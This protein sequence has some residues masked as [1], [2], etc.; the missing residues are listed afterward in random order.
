MKLPKLTDLATLKSTMKQLLDVKKNIIFDLENIQKKVSSL[1]KELE[2]LY[3]KPLSRAEALKKDLL[4]LEHLH[5][6]MKNTFK[7]SLLAKIERVVSSSDS[8]FTTG[9]YLNLLR[10]PHST[11]D[12][13]ELNHSISLKGDFQFVAL[14]NLNEAKKVL[15]DIYNS[16]TDAE[17]T[18]SRT[19]SDVEKS[20]NRIREIEKEIAELKLLKDQIITE[21]NING[22]DI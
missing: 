1:E 10:D 8:G 20:A 16:I 17:W 9:S 12:I 21:A 15:T 11:I 18:Q 22:I 3:R 19:I 6:R 13:Y 4:A 5:E 14:F 7:N 2:D